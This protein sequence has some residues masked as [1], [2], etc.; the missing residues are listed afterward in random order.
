ERWRGALP[1][2]AL[3]AELGGYGAL[4][5]TE[6]RTDRGRGVV[7]VHRE[8]PLRAE[9][10]ERLDRRADHAVLAEPVVE[11]HPRIERGHPGEAPGTSAL[12]E[13]GLAGPVDGVRAQGVDRGPGVGVERGP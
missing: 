5:C 10:V 11:V 2:R 1:D 13:E 6:D 9:D 12:E 7:L 8:R 4:A 3:S